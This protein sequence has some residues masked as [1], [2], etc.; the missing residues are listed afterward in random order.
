MREPPED[1][2]LFKEWLIEVL[3]Q[4]NQKINKMLVF[5]ERD[6]NTHDKFRDTEKYVKSYFTELTKIIRES[7]ITTPGDVVRDD[8]VES[9]SPIAGVREI[10]DEKKRM[11]AQRDGERQNR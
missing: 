8:D 3:T 9:P 4:H 1:R 10:A 6:M 2:T 7:G 5:M 11:M